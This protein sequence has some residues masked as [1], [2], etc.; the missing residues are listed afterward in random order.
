MKNCLIQLGVKMEKVDLNGNKFPLGN[1]LIG[2]DISS[3]II[4]GV[5]I[6][7]FKKPDEKLDVGN[8]GTTL[9]LISILCSRFDFEVIIDG[10]LSMRGRD[11]KS[12]WDSMTSSGV[13]VSFFQDEE[14]PFCQENR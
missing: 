12:L 2:D 6:H 10:D 9:R 5:G 1:E 3:V 8:S 7:G 11:T 13:D 14:K 4:H